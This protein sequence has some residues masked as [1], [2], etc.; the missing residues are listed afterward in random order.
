M[1]QRIFV[2]LFTEYVNNIDN[3]P[4]CKECGKSVRSLNLISSYDDI[5]SDRCR[6]ISLLPEITDNYI[7]SLDKKGGSFKYTWYGHDKVEQYLKNKFKDE[8]R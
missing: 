5:C 8:Y 6:N 2:K 3:I 7:K 4:K 1:I